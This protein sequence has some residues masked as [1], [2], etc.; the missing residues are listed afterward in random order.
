MS[1]PDIQQR[2][3]YLLCYLP[4]DRLMKDGINLGRRNERQGRIASDNVIKLGVVYMKRSLFQGLL[5]DPRPQKYLV[6]IRPW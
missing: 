4:G 3:I 2:R 1:V 6:A 5:G